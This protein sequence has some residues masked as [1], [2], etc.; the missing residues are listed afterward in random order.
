[1][2]IESLFHDLLGLGTDWRVKEL[3]HL[4]GAHSEVRIVIEATNQSLRGLSLSVRWWLCSS[5]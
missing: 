5:L 2:S 1:M 4:P 3:A